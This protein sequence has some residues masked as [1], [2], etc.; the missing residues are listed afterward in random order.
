MRNFL[1]QEI[2]LFADHSCPQ[3]LKLEPSG[4]RG[5]NLVAGS[6]R[7]NGI[8][9]HRIA[10]GLGQELGVAT[11]FHGDEPPSRVIH[12]AAD[13]E[14]SMIAEDGCLARTESSSNS[15]TF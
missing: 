7:M 12:C 4:V 2:R 15:F 1:V 5:S 13:G 11:S 3:R 9:L 10:G 8:D 6:S 14:E